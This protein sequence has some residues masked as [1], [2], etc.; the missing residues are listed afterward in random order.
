MDND[1]RDSIIELEDSE[2]GEVTE[3]IYADTFDFNGKTYAVLLTNAEKEEDIEMVIM[4]ETT[5]DSDEIMLKTIDEDQEDIIYDYYDDLCDELFE[6]EE[7]D[8]ED[9][10]K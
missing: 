10:D 7:E 8:S 5:D 4:E 9:D 3:F 1:E 6:D 2:T